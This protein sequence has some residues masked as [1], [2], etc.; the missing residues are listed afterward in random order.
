MLVFTYFHP[1]GR[2][3]WLP[4]KWN[5]LFIAIN[6][7]RIFHVYYSRYAANNFMPTELLERY[8]KSF[9]LMDKVDF[10]RL[11]RIAEI[12]EYNKGEMIL[13]QG[14]RVPVVRMV[15]DGKLKV[16]RDGKLTY[17]LHEN[18][19][20]SEAGIHIGLLLP[21]S[22]ESCGSVIVESDKVRLL[23]W[24][25]TELVHL[26]EIHEGLRRSLKAI[27]SWDIVRKLKAQRTLLA[28]HLITDTDEWTLLRNQQTTYRYA[29]LLQAV[30]QS[31]QLRHFAKHL[32]RYRT[33]HHI[34][35]ETH[36]IALKQCGWTEEEF[37]AGRRQSRFDS[38]EEEELLAKDQMWRVRDWKWYLRDI[39]MRLTG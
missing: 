22:I 12:K 35:D 30:L 10:Y 33:V 31:D 34:D 26:L 16:L 20:V 17:M 4:F 37:A 13:A 19:F 25:R 38:E 14:E 15:L 1:H 23:C 2:V 5:L 7:Y 9:F 11:M 24:E 29:A 32:A 36:A 39:Y 8:E 28:D 27:M 6:C 21:G 3:L 18:N